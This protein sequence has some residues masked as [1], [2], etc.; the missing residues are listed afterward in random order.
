MRFEAARSLLVRGIVHRR[1][2]EKRRAHDDLS[3]AVRTFDE[4]GATAW[5]DKARREIG[6]IGLR[7]RARRQL[8][9][10]EST[11]ARLAADGR[12]NREIAALAFMSPRTVEGVLARVYA[13]LAIG[14]RAEL[15]RA[16]GSATNTATNTAADEPRD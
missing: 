15:G 5:S 11:V 10:T 2:R 4:L 16:F 13:K 6:R 14:S 9:D 1:R 8:T 3:A 12:T 7:P